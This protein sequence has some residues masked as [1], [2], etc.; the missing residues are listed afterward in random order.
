MHVSGVLLMV[1][2][3]LASTHAQ[4]QARKGY[5]PYPEIRL[6]QPALKGEAAIQAL[7]AHARVVARHYGMEERDLKRLLRVDRQARISDRGLL[8]YEEPAATFGDGTIPNNPRADDI[9]DALAFRLHSRPGARSVLYINHQGETV[10]NSSWNASGPIVAVPYSRDADS[11][12]SAQ[13]LQDVKAHWL[14]VAEDYAPFDIDVTTERPATVDGTHFIEVVV[15]PTSEW[16]GS[17]GGVCYVRSFGWGGGLGNQVCWV[18]S[19]L[20]GNNQKYVPEA[21]SHEAGHALG[22]NHWQK[23]DP[24]TG[25]LVANYY[26]GNG[27]WAPIMGVGYYVPVVTWSRG[28]YPGA[29]TYGLGTLQ[30]DMTVIQSMIGTTRPDEA[31]GTLAS[32]TTLPA[33]VSNGV[34]RVDTLGVISGSTDV[35]V[36]R[37]DSAGGD[38]SLMV[39]P[40]LAAPN[41]DFS[42][43][44]YDAN[45]AVIVESDPAGVASVPVSRP[46]SAPGTYYLEIA[47]RGYGDPMAG[48]Y[49]IYGSAGRYQVVG[50]YPAA[51]GT[52]TPTP[53]PQ[54]PPQVGISNPV[55]G[56]TVTYKS[57]VSVAALA[58]DDVRVRKVRILVDGQ[59]VCNKNTHSPS[60]SVSCNY[61]VREMVGSYLTISAE[62]TDDAGNKA[63]STA[64]RVTVVR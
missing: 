4:A 56:G 59:Q 10:V 5:D 38:I 47:P 25:A 41:V 14:T 42:V 8:F 45:R 31:P 35:D 48:G 49:P 55:H 34:A 62:A 24:A 26:S 44:L 12:F 18:F 28:E 58:S 29:G 46:A 21:I 19:T 37:F 36:Y 54:T 6:G 7:G 22:L 40:A 20:L 16:Y 32:A 39:Q 57:N 2:S 33:A 61:N 27:L 17:A 1:A 23:Y 13:E 63:T 64:I 60:V 50:Q 43:R 11:A 15:T 51:G 9:S 52:P 3:V 53:V 30:N